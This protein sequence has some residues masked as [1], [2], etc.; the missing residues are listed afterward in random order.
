MT[1]SSLDPIE[2][3]KFSNLADTWWDKQ[4]PLKTLHD[5]N[6]ARLQFISQFAPIDGARILDIG[7]GGG[8]LSEA[9]A[10]LN[11]KVSAI[12]ASEDAITIA[13]NHAKASEI[14]IDYQAI[15]LE[16]YSAQGF[17]IITCME[18]LEHVHEPALIIQHAAKLLKPGGKL[19]LSTLNRSLKS[20][21]SAIIGAE[22]ILQILPKQ[23]HDYDKFIKPSELAAS[24]RQAG[25][26]V[27]AIQGL[28]YQPITRLAALCDDVSVNYLMVCEKN[29]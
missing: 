20:Y 21:L 14:K 7:C 17:D 28:S 19:F 23:T 5:I 11:A 18:M 6:P 22:Y 2:V 27:L 8:I 16:D 29:S 3:A 4:G 12:D 24:V 1:K 25:L 13:I 26:E 10:R 9:M 15:L